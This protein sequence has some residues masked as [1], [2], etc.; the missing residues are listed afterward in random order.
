MFCPFRGFQSR[1]TDSSGV[2]P[3]R[4]AAMNLIRSQRRTS[5]VANA[6]AL[7]LHG[8]RQRL[9]AS[10]DRDLARIIERFR[11]KR[12]RTTTE[13]RGRFV[14]VAAFSLARS[15]LELRIGCRSHML[16]PDYSDAH[17]SL[18]VLAKCRIVDVAQS[19]QR[20]RVFGA[21]RRHARLPQ[22][23][24]LIFAVQFKSWQQ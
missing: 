19:Q 8:N 23:C 1:W 2:P 12:V 11:W 9:L 22:H 13:L 3:A 4:D 24:Q 7:C 14:R 17:H 5:F 20:V 10:L 16:R 6:S 15:R 21:A 18:T